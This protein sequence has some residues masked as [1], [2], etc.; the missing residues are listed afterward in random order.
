MKT[1][2]QLVILFR[3]NKQGRNAKAL[4]APAGTTA[5]SPSKATSSPPKT[6]APS[7]TGNDADP[8]AT[9]KRFEIM[10]VLR[11]RDIDYSDA[12]N[13]A[14]LQALARASHTNDLGDLAAPET[15]VLDTAVPT[16]SRGARG[17]PLME[18][19]PPP[20]TVPPPAAAT[21]APAGGD[22]SALS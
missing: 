12:R 16:P 5:A 19:A 11:Q 1:A 8:Y 6:A 14:D 9:M 22:P 2:E 20:R 21:A 17:P 15:E 18:P 3:L 10:K 7:E 13:L 4:K